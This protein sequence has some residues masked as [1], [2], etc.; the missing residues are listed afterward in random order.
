M[1]F[2]IADRVRE[3]STTIGTGNFT[4]AGAVT[5][6]QTFDAALDTGDTTYYTIADQSGANWEVGIGTFTSP[7]TIARTTI[8]SS[9]NG[10]SVVTFGAGTK[11]VFISLPA[12]KTNVED[13]PNL[14]E[15]NS[16][17]AAL[18][19][20]QT[21]AGNALVVEDSAN[22]D[23]T[24]FVVD[25]SGN[26]GIGTSSPNGKFGVSDGTVQIITAPYGAGLTGY[27]GTY[28]NSVL[29]FITNNTER[30]RIDASGNVGIG[31]S[32]P[33]GKLD[34]LT[35]TYR[36]YFD[37]ASGSLFRLNGVNA[38]NSAY[39]PMS[40]NGSIL[41]FQTGASERARI[42]SSGNVGIGTSSPGALL[43]INGGTST[44][45]L[46][47]YQGAGFGYKIGR[48]TSDGFLY[49]Y[50]E[51]SGG[52]GYV[53]SGANGERMRIDTS[54][55][56]G[57]GTGLPTS[58]LDVIGWSQ[59]TTNAAAGAGIRVR[60][61]GGSGSPAL[62]QFTDNPVTAQWGYISSPASNV[63]AFG[64]N[65]EYARFGSSGVLLVGT[66]TGLAGHTFQNSSG[67]STYRP[68]TTTGFGV[69]HFYSDVSGTSTLKAYVQADGTY[70]NASDEKLKTNIVKAR[71]YLNDLMRIEIV[72]YTWKGGE[73]NEK[74]LGVIAQQV[75]SVF[76]SLVK[77]VIGSPATGETQKML[78][79]G[80]FIPMLI[81]AIQ[82]L[83]ADFDAYKA[84][85]P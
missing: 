6:Y 79:Q 39:G 28:T 9:S 26:V 35:G 84:A 29:A 1:A 82:E 77:E 85:H 10:G 38:A 7:A 68:T 80:V 33:A 60:T 23:A 24:P 58:T 8:L 14:I 75:E 55:N 5:G 53:F 34:I 16:S 69:H 59:F 43:H 41:I 52:N 22:P 27:F 73:D 47:L 19:I 37:D 66:T 32:S 21:G 46:R 48:S 49:F 30:A 20:T 56:V 44:D 17:S 67:A 12:S 3:T 83:K 15:V 45:Q 54:G 50:G 72:N 71:S 70:I 2:V 40:L 61:P 36:G 81:T 11:D 78:P 4:L 65:S 51:Q 62:I 42:D 25:A 18:R 63:L 64:G 76:P 31:T 74:K 57:I 13:Q